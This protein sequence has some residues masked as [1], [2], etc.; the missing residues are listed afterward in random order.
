MARIIYKE[1]FER[2]N[3]LEYIE[4]IEIEY[5]NGRKT[6]IYPQYARLSMID[7]LNMLTDWDAEDV[8][9]VEAY[10]SDGIE[11]NDEL[12]RINSPAS[13]FV[14]KFITHKYGARCLPTLKIAQEVADNCDQIDDLAEK[15]EGADLLCDFIDSK[16]KIWTCSRASFSYCYGV[17]T[18]DGNTE[19]LEVFKPNLCIPC[20]LDY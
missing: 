9:D 18:K 10:A 12:Y 1:G 7:N 13:L 2:R 16:S 4:G 15:I 5:G 6:L 19:T 3:E 20:V 8:I 14:S 17:N 11:E